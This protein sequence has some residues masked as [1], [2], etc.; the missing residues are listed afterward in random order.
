[1]RSNLQR[2]LTDAG[3]LYDEDFFEWTRRNAE[4]LR[5]GRLEQVDIEHIAE[6]IE[7]MGKRDLRE[8]DNR[9][10][11]LLMHLLKWHM[12][13][14]NRSRSWER[15]IASQRM[16]IEQV[17]ADSRSLRPRFRRNLDANYAKAIHLAAI[18]TGVPL[19]EFPSGCPFTVAQILDP[20]FLP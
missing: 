13:P 17:M 8:L 6:E 19:S 5:A 4:L 1:M 2:A 12:Q 3:P 16:G 10:R 20:G 7:D 14:T 18:E 11:V 9:A 15:T